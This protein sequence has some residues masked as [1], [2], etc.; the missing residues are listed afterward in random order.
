MR[1]GKRGECD[2]AL[3]CD[4]T[5]PLARV[6]AMTLSQFAIQALSNP[7]SLASRSARKDSESFINVTS[8]LLERRSITEAECIAVVHDSLVALGFDP[9]SPE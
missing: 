2:L 4:L 5:V 3:R 9:G 7:A 1:G 8:M 6:I